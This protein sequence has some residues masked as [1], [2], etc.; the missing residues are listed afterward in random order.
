MKKNKPVCGKCG[1]KVPEGARF[2][3]HCG[4]KVE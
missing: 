1:K 4:D 3:L 2:C